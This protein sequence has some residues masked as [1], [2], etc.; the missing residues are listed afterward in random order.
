MGL[1]MYAYAL[2]KQHIDGQTV[3]LDNITGIKHLGNH[4]Y[5]RIPNED[6]YGHDDDFS[7]WLGHST[8]EWYFRKQNALHGYFEDYWLQN[9]DDETINCNYILINDLL[10]D[11]E[12]KVKEKALTPTAGFFYGST[13]PDSIDWDTISA[14]VAKAQALKKDHFILYSCWY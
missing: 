5:E 10:D 14:F 11:L 9:V 6:D 13:D 8:Q 4:C 3:N 2:K 12:Q 1:D 7:R